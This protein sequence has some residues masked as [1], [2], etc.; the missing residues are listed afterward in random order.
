[1]QDKAWLQDMVERLAL[2]NKPAVRELTEPIGKSVRQIQSA[3]SKSARR[4]SLPG[5][6]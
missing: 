2:Q 3:K 6:D 1:M 4:R 5:N